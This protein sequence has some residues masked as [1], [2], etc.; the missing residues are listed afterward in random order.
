[1]RHR[2]KSGK[3]TPDLFSGTKPDAPRATALTPSVRARLL[4]LLLVL[5]APPAAALESVELSAPGASSALIQTLRASSLLIAAQEAGRT[6]PIDLLAAARAEYGRLLSLLYEQGHYAPQI[7]VLMDGR[8]AADIAP[9]S[10]PRDVSR[11]EVRIDL[12]P[13]FTF[14]R[15]EV[16][17][18]APGS[19]LP[20]DLAPGQPARTTVLRAAVASAMQDWRAQ[21]HALV[22]V[23]AQQVTAD[24]AAQR[25][26]LRL[27]LAP[28]P[29][30]RIG[31]VAARGNQLTRDERV[32]AIAGLEPGARFDPADLEAAEARLRRTGA[33]TAVVL[34]PA[35][36]ANADGTLD[37]EARVDEGL[38]RRLG[39][40]VEIDS[41]SGGRLSGFWLHRNLRGGA[42]RLRLEAAIDGIGAQIGGL[43]FVLDARYTRPATLNPDTD[44]ELGF[45]AARINETDQID[46]FT[47]DAL[48]RWRRSPVLSL[49]A[50]ASLRWEAGAQ[51]F[52]TLGLP[53]TLTRDTRDAAMDA[54]GGHYL[55]A[56]VMPYVGFGAADDG[57]RLRLD[58][59]GY[60]DAGSGGRL[61]L[62]GRAQVGALLGSDLADAPRGFLFYSGGGG[63]VR[64]LPYQSLGVGIPPTSGGMG[65]AALSGEVRYRLNDSF[66]V[67]AFADAG[68]VSETATGGTGDWQAGGGL[69][70]RYVTPIG[71]LR[72]DLATPLRRNTGVTGSR[73]QVYLG[74]GQAF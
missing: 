74:I 59:R 23:A 36:R 2:V 30:L 64:G 67:V 7:R 40:G 44:L 56:E 17:P 43:G 20:A 46:A 69:G 25:L 60:T 49:T 14:G 10:P 31:Q 21:G 26:N 42:E 18:L 45:N 65:F 9:L 24:H 57:L 34:V 27:V 29:S 62:A 28:G 8:E 19:V 66:S 48:L 22:D 73:V 70:V 32:Q 52:G 58:A 55:M 4:A 63:S 54:T 35:E 38:P 15:V 71:P 1:M 72:L 33:F 61:V 68:A 5:A 3:V 51:D 39:F 47:A 12:G 50:G 53:L 41:Q 13:L 6:A 37:I 11:I 16:G